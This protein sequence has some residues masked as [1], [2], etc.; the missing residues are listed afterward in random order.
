MTSTDLGQYGILITG[1]SGFLGQRLANRLL[2]QGVTVVGVSRTPVHIDAK[3]SPFFHS[4]VGDL[5]RQENL[6]RALTSLIKTHKEK[7]AIIH[8]AGINE[9]KKCYTNPVSAFNHNTF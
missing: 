5:L 9:Q 3:K 6:S 2:D 7:Y 4:F 1:V 8:R